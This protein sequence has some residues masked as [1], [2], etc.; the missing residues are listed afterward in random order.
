MEIVPDR[1]NLVIQSQVSPSDADDVYPGQTAQVRF[2]SVHDRT[3]PLLEG[4]VRTI[5]ADRLTDKESGV[6]YFVAEVEVAPSELNKVRDALG[7]GQ[8]RPGLPV[9]VVLAARKRT[10]LDYLL[11]PL[12]VHFWRSLREQ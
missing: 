5:S 6:S 2:L 1:R 8:L 4:T 11:E 9:E 7:Q 10:A 12:T 3:L